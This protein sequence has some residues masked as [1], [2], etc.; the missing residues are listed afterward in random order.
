MEDF[1]RE[2][3]RG[4]VEQVSPPTPLTPVRANNGGERGSQAGKTVNDKFLVE[5][6]FPEARVGTGHREV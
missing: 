2:P 1:G 4:C 6:W 3:A 5:S